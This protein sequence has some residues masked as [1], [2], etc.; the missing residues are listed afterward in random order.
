[1]HRVFERFF[2]LAEFLGALAVA[3]DGRVFGEPYDLVEPL[4]FIV[5]VK[6]TSATPPRGCR[7]PLTAWRWR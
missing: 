6:D 4:T 5:V 7:C 2:F 3:P 1:M